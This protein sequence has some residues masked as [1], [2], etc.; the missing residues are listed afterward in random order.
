MYTCTLYA[1]EKGVE[2]KDISVLDVV[3]E[4]DGVVETPEK[5]DKTIHV[6]VKTQPL[7]FEEKY[8]P[9][10]ELF[11]LQDMEKSCS[12]PMALL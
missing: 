8:P 12:N 3:L 2:E 10:A 9:L 7:V 4:V 1:L 5:K 6:V 11:K